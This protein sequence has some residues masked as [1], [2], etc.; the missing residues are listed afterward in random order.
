M[1]V[2]NDINRTLAIC[3]DGLQNRLAIADSTT[4]VRLPSRLLRI[5]DSETER[6]GWRLQS[7][8]VVRG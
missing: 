7:I 2:R 3:D 8:R 6:H 4:L 5:G 1:P